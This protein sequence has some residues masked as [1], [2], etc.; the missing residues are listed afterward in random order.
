MS[1][2][3]SSSASAEPSGEKSSGRTVPPRCGAYNVSTVPCPSAGPHHDTVVARPHDEPVRHA[4]PV[5]GPHGNVL[6]LRIDR[7]A[8][9]LAGRDIEPRDIRVRRRHVRHGIASVG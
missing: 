7:Q 5:A 8:A 2:P 9:L 1:N 4:L 6:G 3:S